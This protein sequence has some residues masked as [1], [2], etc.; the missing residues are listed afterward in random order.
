MNLPYLGSPPGR[1]SSPPATELGGPRE[2]TGEDEDEAGLGGG[3][4]AC[5]ADTCP[6]LGSLK[7]VKTA[8]GVPWSPTP[9]RSP[10]CALPPP[11]RPGS[12]ARG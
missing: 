4:C 1:S 6:G 12:C 3:C 7:L 2:D 9:M 10:G 8:C 11:G 5:G